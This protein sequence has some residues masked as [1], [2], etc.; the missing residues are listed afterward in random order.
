MY[1]HIHDMSDRAYEA[2]HPYKITQQIQRKLKSPS[3]KIDSMY[4]LLSIC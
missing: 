4:L 1:Y 2:L 3:L